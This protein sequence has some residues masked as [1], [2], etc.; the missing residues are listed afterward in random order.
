MSQYFIDCIFL[1]ADS[2]FY[3]V[4]VTILAL[5]VIC[6]AGIIA[7][8]LPPRTT[9]NRLRRLAKSGFFVLLFLIV[10]ASFNLIWSFAIW[11]NLYYSTDYCGLD[12]LPFWPISQGLIDASYRNQRGHLYKVSLPQLQ[13][14][15]FLFQLGI[16]G[17]AV[18]LYR[19]LNVRFLSGMESILLSAKSRLFRSPPFR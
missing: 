19:S 12:C 16:W 2:G 8:L 5:P 1:V 9:A 4:V 7:I 18:L 15:W 3:I 17:T 10:G 13:F 6:V 11:G 14:I